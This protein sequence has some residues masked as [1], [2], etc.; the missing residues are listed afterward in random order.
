MVTEQHVKHIT[1][2]LKEFGY[3][4]TQEYVQEQVDLILANPQ[5]QP[6]NIIGVMAKGMLK[7]ARLLNDDTITE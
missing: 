7:E 3:P 4:V 5:E 1:K 6:N 2:N